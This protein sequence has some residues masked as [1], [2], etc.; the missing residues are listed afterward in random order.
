MT[1]TFLIK[2]KSGGKFIHPKGGDS[3]P[4]NG[5]KLLLH[6]DIH[7]K[8]Y[9]KFDVIEGH[10]GYI[11]H[12]SSGKIVHPD[13]GQLFPGDDTNLVLHSDHHSGALFALD[14]VDDYI[15]HKGGKFVHPDGGSPNPGN[16]T[17]VVLHKD[18]HDAMK[19]QFV[20]P[21]DINKEVLIYGNTSVNGHWRRINAIINPK[22]EHTHTISYTVGKSKTESRSSTFS[23]KWEVSGGILAHTAL[24]SVTGSVSASTE[25]MIKKASSSTWS[26]EKTVTNTIIVDPGKTVVTWQYVFDVAQCDHKAIFHSN[27]LADTDDVMNTPGELD[28]VA[29]D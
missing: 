3:H 14:N 4:S 7:D 12:V 2:H 9:F 6:Q 22:A 21:H 8:M 23:F 18:K 11:R 28:G 5:T 25:Y 13:G 26:E 29:Y 15:I 1:S 17:D 10:W 16:D 19:F 27:I 20:S 24:G